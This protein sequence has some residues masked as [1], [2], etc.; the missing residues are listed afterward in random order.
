[1]ADI[2]TYLARPSSDP[3]ERM[4]RF[5][6]LAQWNRY[7]SMQLAA[8]EGIELSSEHWD[9]IVFLREYYLEH[10]WPAHTDELTRILDA[11]FEPQ[12]GARYLYRLFPR[13]PLAQGTRIAGLP[14][15]ADVTDA[16]FG[17]VR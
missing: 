15:P 12:G 5:V 14:A 9:V 3:P 1:M 6:E 10:G 7:L 16:S 2:N 4:D 13:G 11:A 8:S 17:T